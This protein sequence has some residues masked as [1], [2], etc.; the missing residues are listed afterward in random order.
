[1][2]WDDL[3]LLKLM[4]ELETAPQLGDLSNGLNLMQRAA[5]NQV[6]D[7][8]Y[9]TSTFARELLLAAA[10]GYVT[11]TDQ[12][13]RNVGVT[14]P[15]ANSQSWLQMIWELRLTLSGRD[16]ARGRIIERALPDPDEDD[17]RPIAGMTL[18]EIARVIGGTYTGQQL[19]KYLHDSGIP[20]ESI[21]AEMVG[22]KWEYVLDVFE[23]LHEGGSASRR[24]LREFLGGWIEG[25]HHVAPQPEFRARVVGLLGNQG[26][27]VVDQRLVIGERIYAAAAPLTPLGGDARIAALHADVRQVADKYLESGHLEVA[28]FEAFKAV[29]VRVKKMTSLTRDGSDLMSQAFSDNSP[30]LVVGDLSTETGKDIQAGYRF[31]FM[32]AARA[33]RNPDAHEP[34]KSLGTEEAL[35]MLAFASLLMRRLDAA[36][37]PTV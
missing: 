27:H 33:I 11:W 8:N 31:L 10:A 23:R 20:D 28:I 7:W 32:G 1:M 25:Q 36:K 2:R 21:P 9:D 5:Q 34:F 37:N 3:Q 6:V 18:E 35:E 12:S 24:L 29:I 26:W 16:R 13:G 19:P 4:D 17:G 22:S 14:D 30:S 15:I